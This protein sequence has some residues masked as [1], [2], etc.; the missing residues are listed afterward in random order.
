MQTHGRRGRRLLGVAAC[1]IALLGGGC[2]SGAERNEEANDGA[3][4][5]IPA[6]VR[7]ELRALLVDEQAL[8]D[9]EADCAIR[10]LEDEIGEPPEL[11]PG[12]E[13]PPEIVQAAF[14]AG[15]AC[16]GR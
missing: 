16:A 1:A 7:S 15:V 8:T 6:D 11:E 5:G 9:S 14:E 13:L 2:G 4:E 10:R 12:G 3:G